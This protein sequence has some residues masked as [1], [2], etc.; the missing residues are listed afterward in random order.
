MQDPAKKIFSK[1]S[2]FERI[3]FQIQPLSNVVLLVCMLLFSTK[4][5]SQHKVEIHFHHSVGK[6][7]L[8][9]DSAYQNN[10]GETFSIRKFRYY[11][12]NLR[13]YDTLKNSIHLVK[14]SYFLVDESNPE[15][16]IISLNIPAGS[17]QKLSFM[18]GVDSIRNVSGA[19]TGALDPLNDMFWTWRSGYVMAKLEGSSPVSTLPR[20][21]FEYHIGGFSGVNSV[22]RT[23]D[24]QLTPA[25]AVNAP[26]KTLLNISVDV[27]AWFNAVHHLPIAKTPACTAP[28]VLAKSYA[29]NFVHMF[30]VQ[31]VITE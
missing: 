19:Q 22:L 24:L 3:K 23:T 26:T 9:F 14:N 11:I 25:I 13:F 5:Q 21:M 27:N 7:T 30:L 18:I 17:Y 12:S 2:A 29:E 20:R 6:Q 4:A 16:K 10:L 15:S 28:G 8:E 1:R 31:S